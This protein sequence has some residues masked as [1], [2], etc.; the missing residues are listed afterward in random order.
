MYGITFPDKKL[1]A[2]YKHRMEEAR[3][4]DH[5]RVGTQME[6]FF[7]HQL[8]P[9]SCFFLPNGGRVYNTLIEVGLET[10]P[11]QGLFSAGCVTADN[12]DAAL[13]S[14]CMTPSGIGATHVQ[15]TQSGWCGR[16]S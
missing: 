9:G 4:R 7:F 14:T 3:K 13:H 12:V 2:D 10:L 11:S 16:C 15:L 5:R 1:M 8:S 6:L